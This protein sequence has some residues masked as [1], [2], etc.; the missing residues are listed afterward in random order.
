MKVLKKGTPPGKK[1]RRTSCP[2]CH[3]RFEFEEDEAK[4]GSDRDGD[5]LEIQCPECPY[6][7]FINVST[8]DTGAH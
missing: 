3:A 5:Y 8:P 6:Q 7:I 4:F 2:S 1:L